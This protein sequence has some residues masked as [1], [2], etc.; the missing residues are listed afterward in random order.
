MRRPRLAAPLLGPL[1]A[2]QP[3]P[4]PQP[5]PA[6][7]PRQP[8]PIP[9]TTPPEAPATP[10]PLAPG[11][12]YT[13][14]PVATTAIDRGVLLVWSRHDAA[15][16]KSDVLAQLLDDRGAP[17][18]Q[19]RLVRRTSGEVLDLAVDR[20]GPAAW[21]AWVA[22]LSGEA[23]LTRALAAAVRIEPDLSGMHSPL[24]LHQFVSPDLELWP[25]KLVRVR[26]LADGGAAIA[27]VSTRAECTDIVTRRKSKCA[28]HDL[29]WVRADGTHSLA[30]HVGA[31]GGEPDLDSLVDVGTGVLLDLHAWHGGATYK[32]I[33]AAY[34]KPASAP[35][36]AIHHCRPPFIRAWTGDRLITLCPDDYANESETC[37]LT[38][39]PPDALNCYRVH[40]GEAATPLLAET[41]RCV[42]GRPVID[43]RWQGGELRLDP[44]APG[45][46][47]D[48][49]LGA[50]TGT[51]G[52]EL[53]DGGARELRACTE[54]GEYA[55]ID[56]PGD[57]LP[58]AP[59]P[60]SVRAI[61]GAPQT[62]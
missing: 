11:D 5:S 39:D 26:A 48:L 13:T 62:P 60:A 9:A 16:N 25:R 61:P 6:E 3:T 56:A 35:P 24:S 37:P 14:G 7:P 33:Y 4:S 46:S 43:L 20:R 30:A 21:I 19:P 53:V 38:G 47:M 55:P 18:G 54:S 34:H 45:A 36:F 8:D 44:H 28:G 2:C 12:S 41:R 59:D 42:D 40:T 15:T 52:V 49:G 51:H 1:L 50:W 10:L 31:D 17:Q 58:L 22:K 32:T 29:R 27:A 23:E 57:T